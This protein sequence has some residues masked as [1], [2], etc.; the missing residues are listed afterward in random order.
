MFK[1][2]YA[3]GEIRKKNKPDV[4]SAVLTM[5][6]N[7]ISI[8]LEKTKNKNSRLRKELENIKKKS[9]ID[10]DTFSLLD[11]TQMRAKFEERRTI[12]SRIEELKKI[13][14]KSPKEK[15]NR[16]VIATQI[17]PKRRENQVFDLERKGKVVEV[18]LSN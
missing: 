9:R 3:V 16:E 17:S 11:M 1:I 13:K 2:Q 15:K 4:N 18:E 6:F 14:N 7:H 5:D 8:K 12:N 10:R